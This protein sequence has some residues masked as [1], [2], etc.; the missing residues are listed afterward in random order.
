MMNFIY[1]LKTFEII[2]IIFIILLFIVAVSLHI[3]P[4]NYIW[5]LKNKKGQSK[6]LKSG[7]HF[8][9]PFIFRVKSKVLI[10]EQKGE[11]Y[12]SD[13]KTKDDVLV[14]FRIDYSYIITDVSLFSYEYDIANT[15]IE[16]IRG[17]VI[18]IDLDSLSSE[19]KILSDILYPKFKEELGYNGITLTKIMI[20]HEK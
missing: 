20:Y 7:F 18:L 3:V 17:Y 9:L 8:I 16:F 2:Q 19:N 5:I 10:S 1:L 12:L 6:V 4:K 13:V 11:L 15:I 14:S